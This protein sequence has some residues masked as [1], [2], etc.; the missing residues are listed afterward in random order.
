MKASKLIVLA[1]GILGIVAF[2]LP[3][4]TVEHRG[5]RVSASA[6]QV[7]KGIDA[8]QDEGGKALEVNAASLGREGKKAVKEADD[9]LG[10]IKAFVIA[11]FVPALLLA[12]IGGLGVARKRF[13]RVAGTFSLLLGL[14]GLGIAALLQSAASSD[15]D[16]SAGIAL[17][18]LLLTGVAGAVGG[19]MALVKP[20]RAVAAA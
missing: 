17:T 16:G 11:I 5:T 15:G 1:G 2:F 20:E 10:Q 8:I 13:G 9:T 12:A 19:I 18:I 3:M 6:F 14:V 4:V 7:V